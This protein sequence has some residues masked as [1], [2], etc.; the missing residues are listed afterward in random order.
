MGKGEREES[1]EKRKKEKRSDKE[2]GQCWKGTINSTRFS[3]CPKAEVGKGWWWRTVLVVVV[4]VVGREGKE[5]AQAES[6][7]EVWS[8]PPSPS[9]H[10]IH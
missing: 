1:R 6:E 2:R 10:L 4:V 3:A 9:L 7:S 8:R 5:K